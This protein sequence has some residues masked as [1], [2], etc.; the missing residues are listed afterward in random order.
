[1]NSWFSDRL[2]ERFLRYAAIHTTSDRHTERT[3]STDCQWD[4]I[5]LLE[6]ELKQLGIADVQVLKNGYIIAVIPASEG[7][8]APV[9]GLMA[10]V[11]TSEDAPGE[12]VHPRIQKNYDGSVVQLENGITIDPA[13]FPVLAACRGHEII[14]SDGT[15][16]LGAD[17]KAGVAIIMTTAE[18]LLQNPQIRHGAIEI[19]FTPDEETGRGLDLFPHE[20]L[21][22][23]CCYTLDGEQEGRIESECFN[24]S[25]AEITF[26]G[27]MIHPGKARG[28]LI[29]A[30]TLAMHFLQMLPLAE[31]PEATD[32]RYGFYFPNEISG[33]AS[34][35]TVDI[36]LRDFSEITLRQREN[37]LR[38]AAEAVM[39]SAPGSDVSLDITRQYSN[40]RSFIEKDPRVL[41]LLRRAVK[42]AGLE[43]ADEP[44]RGGTDGARLSEL[45][46]P[47][48]NIFTGGQNFHSVREWVS[49]DVMVKSV[50][51]VI[52]LA[53]LWSNEQV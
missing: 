48:P 50:Q 22:A 7:V 20:V 44:I 42:N 14:T 36:L 45:G 24:A 23:V 38:K 3:P 27:R 29:N 1:M 41:D 15:T 52:E 34:Q 9:I 19:V 40:M 53:S 30:I 33:S 2:R 37:C 6:D 17:D 47:T 49:L 12:H 28:K 11:D 16:L 10:H 18:Y 31:S 5:R 39:A 46:I 21:N 8:K 25:R 4:L 26:S 35:L 32:E 13:D 43:P 51:T